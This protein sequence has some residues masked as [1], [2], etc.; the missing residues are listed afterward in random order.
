MPPV[1]DAPSRSPRRAAPDTTATIDR[2]ELKAHII[3][4]SAELTSGRGGL[5]IERQALAT[6]ILALKAVWELA[7]A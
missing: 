3:A 4:L 1:T 7:N 5:P 2:D 6:E